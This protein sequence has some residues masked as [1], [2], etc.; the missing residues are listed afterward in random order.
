MHMFLFGMLTM[1]L[2]IGLMLVICDGKGGVELFD[3]WLVALICLPEVI[4][5]G[6]IRFINVKII[7]RGMKLVW[8]SQKG[9]HW[10]KKEEHIDWSEEVR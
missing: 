2:I 6:I 7:H 1:Y 9:N 8:N 3:G 4:V 10:V 5:F